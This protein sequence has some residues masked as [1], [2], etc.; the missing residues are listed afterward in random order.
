MFCIGIPPDTHILCFVVLQI[1]CHLCSKNTPRWLPV[2][3]FLLSNDVNLNPG[4]TFHNNLLNLVSWNVNSLGNDNFQ[5][6]RL[7]EVHNSIHNYNLSMWNWLEW[8]SG[9]TTGLVNVH[10]I[11]VFRHGKQLMY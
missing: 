11:F 10:V 9:I 8:R 5:R 1:W 2:L 3:L 7:I 6:L 4:P